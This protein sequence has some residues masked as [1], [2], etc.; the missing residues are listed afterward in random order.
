QLHSELNSEYF[1]SS[2]KIRYGLLNHGRK[3]S[4][5][6]IESVKISEYLNF[7]ESTNFEE[8]EYEK[9]SSSILQKFNIKKTTAKKVFLLFSEMFNEHI[10]KLTV[11]DRAYLY[12]FL[13]QMFNV[14]IK[15]FNK[16]LAIEEGV[17]NLHNKKGLLLVLQ[18]FILL[19]INGFM[20]NWN[21]KSMSDKLIFLLKRGDINQRVGLSDRLRKL[22]SEYKNR[23]VNQICRSIGLENNRLFVSKLS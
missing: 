21:N 10:V 19:E 3:F 4:F 2:D 14:E 12:Y 23:S 16:D 20:S 11:S 1:Y 8:I 5:N 22:I 15:E 17:F 18:I 13:H 9:Y 7:I 6:K